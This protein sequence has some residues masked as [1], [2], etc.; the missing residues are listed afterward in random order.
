MQIS[1]ISNIRFNGYSSD[2]KENYISTNNWANTSNDS[3]TNENQSILLVD[4]QGD[5]IGRYGQNANGHIVGYII[6]RTD[7]YKSRELILSADE[8][9]DKDFIYTLM[10]KN[11]N[12]KKPVNGVFVKFEQYT[13]MG[14]GAPK[15][16]LT[17]FDLATGTKT[18]QVTL[19]GYKIPREDDIEDYITM[20]IHNSKELEK[21]EKN[22][23]SPSQVAER[24]RQM[25]QTQQTD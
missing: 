23:L 8:E 9:Q 11:L 22:I 19:K 16:G 6:A 2:K 5:V 24:L 1:A 7:L 13:S 12:Q 4:K 18:M 15:T 20:S 21:T 10:E 17:F 3:F 14:T 25:F